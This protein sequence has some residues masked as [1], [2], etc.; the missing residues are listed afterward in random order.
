MPEVPCPDCGGDE[1]V[2]LLFSRV[3]CETC[4]ESTETVHGSLV[5]WNV[6]TGAPTVEITKTEDDEPPSEDLIIGNGLSAEVMPG[7]DEYA[8][9]PSGQRMTPQDF[10]AALDLFEKASYAPPV[11]MRLEE[12][13]EEE[14][15]AEVLKRC[16]EKDFEDFPDGLVLAFGCREFMRDR[17]W[18][19]DPLRRVWVHPVA[20]R[21][22][23]HVQRAYRLGDPVLPDE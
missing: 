1:W 12:A 10:K 19:Y 21:G 4:S 17:G 20:A 16:V 3:P 11:D 2:T 15:L 18:V 14:L 13:T 7:V 8:L 23:S 6:G 22:R 9:A 5:A